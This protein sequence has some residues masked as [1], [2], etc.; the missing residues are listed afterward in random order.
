[1]I[2]FKKFLALATTLLS[3]CVSVPENVTPV[4]PFELER[5]MG[6]WYEIARLDHPFERGLSQ[7]TAEYSL[8][9][10]GSV[11]VL[12]RGFNA[13]ESK[14]KTAEGKARFARKTHEG[15][16]KVSFFGPFYASYIIFEL[17][18]KNYSYA[19][20]CGPDKSYLWILSRKPELERAVLDNLIQN[21]RDRG[22]P[23][24]ELIFVKHDSAQN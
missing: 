7:V 4:T 21:A 22:F 1:M 10:D 24:R 20:I 2:R 11:K 8:H 13:A 19:T 18:H 9:E 6:R 15:F 5:Y 3:G 23:T 16:L 14:W 12:N 17:D